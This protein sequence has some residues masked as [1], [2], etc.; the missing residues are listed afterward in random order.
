M[1]ELSVV[2]L[3][4]PDEDR[5]DKENHFEELLKKDNRTKS[6]LETIAKRKEE[7]KY[8]NY[9]RGHLNLISN[10]TERKK[11]SASHINLL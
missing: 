7:T 9:E 5:P 1:Q 10:K 8:V 3:K 2:D 6:I 4:K 11:V